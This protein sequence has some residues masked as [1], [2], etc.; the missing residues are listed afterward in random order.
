M[1]CF[2]RECLDQILIYAGRHVERVVREYTGTFVQEYA[3]HFPDVVSVF[4]NIMI[5]QSQPAEGSQRRK[6]LGS[7]TIAIPAL[8]LCV[9]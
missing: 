7:D 3:D 2:R 9:R 6:F 5:R 8:Q 4:L 1:G